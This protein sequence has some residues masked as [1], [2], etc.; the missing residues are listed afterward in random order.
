MDLSTRRLLLRE[1]RAG[2]HPAVHAFAGDVEVTRYTDWGPN[3]PDDTTA[4]LAEA[5]R[6]AR[7]VPRHCFTLAVVERDHDTLVGSIELRVTSTAHRRAEIGYVLNRERWGRGYAAEAA[8]ALLAFGFQDLGLHK[9]S[10]TC[11]PDNAASVRVLT[12]IGMRREGHLRDHL[13][14]RG[15]WRDRLVYAAL[16][17]DR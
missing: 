2:D 17:D 3:N 9:I 10:A 12:R 14:L 5:V 7:A 8:A 16:S 15:R 1:F 11:D 13:H 6:D 4:F